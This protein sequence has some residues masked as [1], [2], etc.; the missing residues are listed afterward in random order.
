MQYTF[1]LCSALESI[2]L[3]GFKASALAN[4]TYTFGA[5]AKLRMIRMDLSWS[6]PAKGLT[7]MGTFC[8][9][10]EA[11]SGAGTAYGSDKTGVCDDAS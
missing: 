7:G 2:D 8:G 10:K 4:L 9:R 6:L 1:N 11:L 5:C 3:S